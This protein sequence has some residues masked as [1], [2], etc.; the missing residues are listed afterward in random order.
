MR[1]RAVASSIIGV[2]AVLGV[3]RTAAAVTNFNV[4]NSGAS[5]YVIG[6]A[7]NPTL[8]LTRGQ[9]YTFSVSA[10]GH[11][12]W[13]VSAPGAAEVNL[14]AFTNGVTGNGTASGTV[15]FVVPA[16]APA[17]LFYQCGFHDVMVGQ[18]NIVSAPVPAGG[19]MMVA[20]LAGLLL[21]AAIVFLR[22]RAGP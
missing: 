8:T 11:P 5:A 6:G 16:S 4:T 21:L 17:T 15:T 13:V 2:V 3:A 7:N 20:V 14:N 19:P 22:R 12:F 10:L 18:L 1:T 9:T